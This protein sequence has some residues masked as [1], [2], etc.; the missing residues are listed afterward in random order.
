LITVEVLD[1]KPDEIM[2]I[3]RSLREDGLVQGRDFDFAYSH[4]KYDSDGWEAVQNRR[5]TFT[6]YTEEYAT[7]FTLKYL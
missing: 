1:L 7:M 4:A 6:F 3:V 5:T 2:P